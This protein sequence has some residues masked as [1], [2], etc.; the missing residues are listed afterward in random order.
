[1]SSPDFQSLNS[2]GFLDE[3]PLEG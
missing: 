1:M 2:N 3:F